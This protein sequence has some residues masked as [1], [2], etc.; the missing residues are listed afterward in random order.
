MSAPRS[1]DAAAPA[2]LRVLHV[3]SSMATEAGGPP[4]VCAGLAEA[5]AARGHTLTIATI[6][7]AIPGADPKNTV[8]LSPAVQLVSFPHD[9]NTRYLS[10]PALDAWL[11]SHTAGFDIVHLHSIWQFPTFAA[12]RACWKARKPYVVLL[13]GMLDQYVVN[14]KSRW[15]KQAYWLYREA[16]IEGRSNGIHFLNEAE[17]RHAVPWVRN[18][19]KFIIGN[20]IRQSEIDGLPPRGRFRAAHP[21]IADRPLALFLSRMHPKKG[22]DRLIPAWKS[23][24]VARPELRFAIA[25]T[26][27]PAYLDAI[28]RLI[29]SDGLQG[30][31]LR[32]GQLVGEKKWEALVD[33][34]L[35]LLPSHQEG[36]SM[37]ITEA[38]AAR[39]P[40]VAT[41]ECNFDELETRNCG[42][43]IRNG[44]MNAFTQAV[45]TL[46][47]DPAKREAMGNAGA[48]FVRERC[49]WEK[50]ACDLEQVYRHILSGAPLPVDGRPLW[51]HH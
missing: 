25:G 12:A 34:D 38:L 32:V 20:G 30:K 1:A 10:S 44:D 29:E 8:P 51:R 27:D 9:G 50:I 40:V 37:A 19:P 2:R 23:L 11:E 13:N 35:F 49:S 17:I 41:Q 22:L 6:S 3:I 39:C 24:A 48:A 4:A 28:D 14:K 15:L 46:L 47:D 36:F 7:N 42:I 16:R 31:V 21:D 5:L 45:T 33:A 43:I 26:G 18:M